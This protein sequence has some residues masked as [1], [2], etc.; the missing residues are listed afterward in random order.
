MD[1]TLVKEIKRRAALFC[2]DFSFLQSYQPIIETAMEIGASIILE[3]GVSP[4]PGETEEGWNQV[5]KLFD[6]VVGIGRGQYP[7]AHTGVVPPALFFWDPPALFLLPPTRAKTT[8][9]RACIL[10]KQAHRW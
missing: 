9:T 8:G 6:S 1:D 3:Q 10:S 7:H 5:E 2:M 4:I